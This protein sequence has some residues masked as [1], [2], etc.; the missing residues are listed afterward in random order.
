MLIKALKIALIAILTILTVSCAV[1]AD[2]IPKIRELPSNPAPIN[3][4][5][6]K[7]DRNNIVKTKEITKKLENNLSITE[8]KEVTS[9][10]GGIAEIK[11]I[12]GKSQYVKFDEPLKRAFI[13]N[14]K[15]AELVQV[16]PTELV[17]D[18]KETGETS[19]LIWGTSGKNPVIFNLYVQDNTLI[20]TSTASM[21]NYKNFLKEARKLAPNEDIKIELVDSE[22]P[23]EHSGS[24]IDLKKDGSNSAQQSDK[25]VIP[26]SSHKIII[27]GKF[28][29]TYIKDKVVALANSYGYSVIN[30]SE[31]LTPQVMISLKVVEMNRDK[32][33]D[34]SYKYLK[35]EL[36]DDFF[37]AKPYNITISAPSP[38][39]PTK[40]VTN[41]EAISALHQWFSDPTSPWFGQKDVMKQINLPDG[42]NG[43]SL[44]SWKITG[45][46]QYAH[47]FQMIETEHLGQVLAE[48]KLMAI[49]GHKASFNSGEQVPIVKG[50][51]IYGGLNIEYRD[52]G[53]N[54]EFTPTILEDSGRILLD[55]TPEINEAIATD[56][57]VNG[58]PVYKFN[59]R[60]TSTKVELED[61]ETIV[62]GGLIQKKSDTTKSKFPYLNNI[63]IIGGLL[64]NT[65]YTQN[66]T[67]LMIF[68]TPTI[69]KPDAVV[70]GV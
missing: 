41:N 54:I 59:T 69:V 33:K 57:N 10:K 17:I 52:T 6:F 9:L 62:I 4:Q 28:S 49:N 11:V 5:V 26:N 15:C 35:G 40:T 24:S 43:F 67:E 34:K 14:E 42:S 44:W 32:T 39:D 56:N 68:V 19:L 30:M 37:Y 66:E 64:N 55:I 18:G 70:N 48:P 58:F 22:N 7:N 51:D 65:N 63:P 2:N 23:L 50:Q 45:D 27:T 29:S 25:I 12:A 8:N 46:Q 13:P 53:V 60:K 21:N 20:S 1:F 16:S 61:N 36:T 47:I 31:S 38:L 3:N